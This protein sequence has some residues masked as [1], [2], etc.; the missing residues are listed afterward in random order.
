MITCSVA[1]SLFPMLGILGTFTAIAISMPDFSIDDMGSLDKQISILLSGIGTAFYASIFGIF[2]S[3]VGYI[4]RRGV[5]LNLMVI[6]YIL[7]AYIKSISGV[8]VS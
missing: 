3:I 6:S 7:R 1:T 5:Y 4:L 8:I 2:L